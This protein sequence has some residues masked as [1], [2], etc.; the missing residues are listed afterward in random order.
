MLRKGDLDDHMKR[1]RQAMAAG[2]VRRSSILEDMVGANQQPRWQMTYQS[3]GQ[4]VHGGKSG[5][6]D[7]TRRSE[8]DNV[9]LARFNKDLSRPGGGAGVS[10][11]VARAR[12]LS[13]VTA[14]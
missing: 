4:A 8:L 2:R 11:V 9:R 13:T 14:G 10:P 3:E 6:V 12:R 7:A 5:G 1:E